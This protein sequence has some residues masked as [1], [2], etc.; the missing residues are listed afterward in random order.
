MSEFE[1]ASTLTV[2]LPPTVASRPRVTRWGTYYAATYKN[3]M[4]ALDDAIPA[5]TITHE[6]KLI[7]DVE[8]VCKKPKTTKRITPLGDIDNYLKAIF[9]ALTKKGYW[10]DD[11]IVVRVVAGKRFAVEDEEPHT[12]ID[13][14]HL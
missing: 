13:I 11:D 7:V 2:F 5:A 8:F 1:N 10:T 9:D 6:G 3:Y 14:E 4:A 12:Y